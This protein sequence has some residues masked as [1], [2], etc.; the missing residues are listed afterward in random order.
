MNCAPKCFA[1]GYYIASVAAD[2]ISLAFCAT[3]LLLDVVMLCHELSPRDEPTL[4]I[5]IYS[6]YPLSG[7]FI[8][9]VIV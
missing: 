7:C 6:R 5:K 4:K 3:V 1:L 8:R 9:V 2:R